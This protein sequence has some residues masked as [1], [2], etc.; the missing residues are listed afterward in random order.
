MQYFDGAALEE[1]MNMIQ[2]KD[3]MQAIFFLS[4]CFL[5]AWVALSWMIQLLRSILWIWPL[6]LLTAL[7]LA[8]PSL[9]MTLTQEIIPKQVDDLITIIDNKYYHHYDNDSVKWY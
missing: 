4:L 3:E 5:G 8:L 7:L 9:R 6:F 2:S 1:L